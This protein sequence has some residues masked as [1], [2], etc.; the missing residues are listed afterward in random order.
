MS[1]GGS[2]VLEENG[3]KMFDSASVASAFNSFYTSVASSLVSKLPSPYG[4]YVTSSNVFRQF[5]SRKL[6][7][8]PNFT[9]S[10]VSSHFIRS[11]LNSLNPKK[12]I[13]LDEIS[14]RFLR[15]GSECIVAPI[16]HIVNLS[17]I[18]ETVPAAFKDGKVVPLFKKGSR[19][20][21]G[22]YRPVSVL[23]VMSKILERA[24]HS[25]LNGYLEKRGLMF[26]NQSGFRGGFST[27]SSLIGLS[28]YVRSEMGKGSMV[29]MVLIDLQKAFD[30]VDHAI[31]LD[32]LA[33]IGVSSV[34]W[35]D[36]YLSDRQQCVDINGTR[37]EFLPVSCGVP[38]G[39]ILGPQLF[40]IYIN[41]LCLSVDCRLSLYADDSALLFSHKDS[42][43]IADRLT[44]E[45]TKCKRW[46]VD[47]KLSLHVGKT[48]C[49]L[50]GSKR[51]LKRAGNF[52]VSCDG[53]AVERVHSVKY[54]G[55][56]L[57]ENL[58]GS[59]H[60]GELVKTC[61]ARLNF[62]YRNHTP[63]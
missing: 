44:V 21:R 49:L 36:S 62:L 35:F 50:F 9:L 45:L 15:D 34:S 31:L 38:Q 51:A 61:S 12:A 29:G 27:D 55:I 43:V 5:Y 8:R 10:P 63:P 2:I 59:V 19:L 4:I 26:E 7:L 41:D 1:N 17:I 11:Q 24:V 20:D 22:N 40:L 25:Q 56:Q 53:A 14:S 52:L 3:R 48:E 58:S 37:S 54:L 13:G 23:N 57:D 28:D 32:K 39:S 47:N 42:S 46:L 60:A 30:T 33:A 18:T 16:T 6:G